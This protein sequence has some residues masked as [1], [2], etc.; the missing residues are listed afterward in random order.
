MIT[1]ILHKKK[2]EDQRNKIVK[3]IIY[4]LFTVHIKGGAWLAPSVKRQTLNFYS[5]PDRRVIRS[6]PESGSMWGLEPA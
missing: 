3:K 6:S 2:T 1:T 4:I 5:G